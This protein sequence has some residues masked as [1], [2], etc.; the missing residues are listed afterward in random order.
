VRALEHLGALTY[1][2]R[3]EDGERRLELSDREAN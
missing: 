1:A 3:L 2:V